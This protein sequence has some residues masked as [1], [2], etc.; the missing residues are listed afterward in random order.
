MATSGPPLETTTRITDP[1]GSI[2]VAAGSCEMIC[3]AGVVGSTRSS[4]ISI[5]A[6]PLSLPILLITSATINENYAINIKI[7]SAFSVCLDI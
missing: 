1:A 2:T 3:P 7:L 6:I 4:M 5:V